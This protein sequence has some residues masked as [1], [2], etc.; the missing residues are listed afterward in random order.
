MLI[1]QGI[2]KI[3]GLTNLI[4][5]RQLWLNENLITALHGLEYCKKLRELYVCSNQIASLENHLLGTGLH[6]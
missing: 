5:L 6:K 2:S 1:Q 3:E 4:E